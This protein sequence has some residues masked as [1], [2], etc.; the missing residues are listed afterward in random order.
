MLPPTTTRRSTIRSWNPFDSCR[1]PITRARVVVI[2]DGNDENASDLNDTARIVRRLRARAAVQRSE[3]LVYAIGIATSGV[4]PLNASAL[5]EITDPSGGFTQ[6]T[7]SQGEV[8]GSASVIAEPLRRQ[9]MVGFVPASLD[10]KFH[11]VKVVVRDC[12]GCH[13]RARAGFI[14]EPAG[15]R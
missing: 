4:R 7:T 6:I 3:A 13:V 12:R 5:R 10:G 14:A 8:E 1:R 9:Y 11:R 2:S 15:K